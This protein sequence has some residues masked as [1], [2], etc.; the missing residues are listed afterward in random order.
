[1]GVL[2]VLARL[3]PGVRPFSSVKLVDG[4]TTVAASASGIKLRLEAMGCSSL[5]FRRRW[6]RATCTASTLAP[7]EGERKW[8]REGTRRWREG[9]REGGEREGRG[10]GE[11][12]EEREGRG[13]EW[14]EK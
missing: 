12:G 8:G 4:V 13:G 7:A 3:L 5:S 9:G 11:G 6:D 14:R 2:S 10:S 1:L